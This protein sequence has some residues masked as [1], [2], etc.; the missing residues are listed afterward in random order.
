MLEPILAYLHIAAFLMMFVFVTSEAALTRSEWLNAA[1]VQ[2][3]VRVDTIYLVALALTLL[4]GLA[5]VFW[6]MKGSA[7]Y[8]GNGLLHLKLTLFF[9]MAILA[10]GPARAFRRWRAA[11]QAGRGLP[12]EHEVKGV[13]RLIMISSHIGML[14]PLAAVF[15]A[16]GWGG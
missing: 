14:L 10:I 13:R 15:M 4:S 5:R 12:P 7:W 16:R 3:L 11:L 9:V 6:G 1:A 2:R 8:W